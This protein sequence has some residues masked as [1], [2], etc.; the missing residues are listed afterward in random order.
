M[1]FG[2]DSWREDFFTGIYPSLFFSL[3][4]KRRKEE[5][6]KEFSATA[7]KIQ[8]NVELKLL[9]LTRLCTPKKNKMH[10]QCRLVFS[11]KHPASKTGSARSVSKGPVSAVSAAEVIRELRLREASLERELRQ[12]Q[13]E[14]RQRLAAVAE[15][16][17]G[18]ICITP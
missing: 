8:E 3:Q 13:G 16:L 5:L 12:L 15:G 14:C 11:S 18:V 2:V 10:G 6:Q 4:V 1:I 7:S 17:D 9:D